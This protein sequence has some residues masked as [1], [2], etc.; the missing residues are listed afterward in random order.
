MATRPPQWPPAARGRACESARGV[1]IQG[2]RTGAAAQPTEVPGPIRGLTPQ[3]EGPSHSLTPGARAPHA[4]RS[5][6]GKVLASPGG[7][8]ASCKLPTLPSRL[9]T[10][11]L[12]STATHT[13][14]HRS[15]PPPA[16]L[17]EVDTLRWWCL[18]RAQAVVGTRGVVTSGPRSSAGCGAG[19]ACSRQTLF[20]LP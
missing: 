7:S 13:E 4:G 16:V 9:D 10:G 19:L 18:P 1:Q 8:P 14:C 11:T 6:W 17:R 20:L 15:T 2:T 12:L 5:L 3:R